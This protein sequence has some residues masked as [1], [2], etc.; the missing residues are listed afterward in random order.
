[1]TEH[2]EVE[3]DIKIYKPSEKDKEIKYIS[4]KTLVVKNTT[5]IH[6]PYDFDKKSTRT[7]RFMKHQSL[8]NSLVRRKDSQI[9]M[10]EPKDFMESVNSEHVDSSENG[11]VEN[12][13]TQ[14]KPFSFF[15]ELTGKE[16]VIEYVENPENRETNRSVKD[17]IEIYINSDGDN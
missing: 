13:H 8:N 14:V 3:D 7:T 11:R 10:M 12:V 17:E 6:Q 2:R 15:R 4:S 9:Q 16:T 5:P 1:M